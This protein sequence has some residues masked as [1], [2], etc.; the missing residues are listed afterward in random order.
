MSGDCEMGKKSTLRQQRRHKNLKIE[1][2]FQRNILLR[3]ST[4]QWTHE[5]LKAIICL[6]AKTSSD[7]ETM[8][9]VHWLI[10]SSIP[11]FEQR[12]YWQISSRQLICFCV[13]THLYDA[14]TLYFYWVFANSQSLKV[15]GLRIIKSLRLVFIYLF[16]A[17]FNTSE[18]ILKQCSYVRVF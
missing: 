12:T 17:A 10:V 5:L 15:S 4:T 11:D 1:E 6:H 18:L 3:A 14:G 9:C 8:S 7:V 2:Y 16:S 13:V